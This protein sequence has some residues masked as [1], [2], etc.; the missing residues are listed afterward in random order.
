MISLSVPILCVSSGQTSVICPVCSKE[1]NEEFPPINPEPFR[2]YDYSSTESTTYDLYCLHDD[3]P[4][5]PHCHNKFS[6]VINYI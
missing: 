4:K 6:F 3:R 1:M 2:E 5:C